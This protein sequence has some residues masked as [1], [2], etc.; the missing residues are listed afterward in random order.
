MIVLLEGLQQAAKLLFDSL[1]IF[2]KYGGYLWNGESSGE[3]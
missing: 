2:A 3:T 1:W